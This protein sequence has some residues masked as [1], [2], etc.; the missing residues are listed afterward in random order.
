M[1]TV[2]FGLAAAAL[3]ATPGPTNTLLAI[4]SATRGVRRSWPLIVAE[5]GGYLLVCAPLAVFSGTW[6]GNH[7]AVALA[8]KLISAGWVLTLA[9]KLWNSPTQATADTG[10]GPTFH[11]VLTTTLLNPKG[12]VFGLVLLPHDSLDGITGRLALLSLLIVVIAS[13]WL[14]IGA[15]LLRH[16]NRRAPGLVQ[17][18]AAT[19]LFGFSAILVWH[20]L[21]A[22]L[23]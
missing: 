23:P 5:L 17:R 16:A 12:L 8:L 13:L 2:A 15:T 7:P 18:A 6:L 3:L 1:D 22:Q 21:G 14:C 19:A 9:I 11:N 4:A 10:R 20:T